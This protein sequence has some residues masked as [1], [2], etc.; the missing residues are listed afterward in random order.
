MTGTILFENRYYVACAFTANTPPFVTIQSKVRLNDQGQMVGKS[1]FS[2][3][4]L[5]LIQDFND[6]DKAE[7]SLICK[8]FFAD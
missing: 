8:S 4:A 3:P 5:K 7:K 6:S 2:E 1:L